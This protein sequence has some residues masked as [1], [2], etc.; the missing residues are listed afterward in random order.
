MAD[1]WDF[2][3]SL[4]HFGLGYGACSH[5][6]RM[7]V[8]DATRWFHDSYYCATPEC[9]SAARAAWQLREQRHQEYMDQQRR[10][11]EMWEAQDAERRK[12]WQ[13]E[14]EMHRKEAEHRA[15]RAAAAEKMFPKTECTRCLRLTNRLR[16]TGR[17]LLCT[18]CFADWER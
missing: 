13:E 17:E 16:L 5:C 18:G 11:Q 6:G 3:E 2:F 8:F 1:N 9:D 12:R 10:A 15:L 4:C 7:S 14:D